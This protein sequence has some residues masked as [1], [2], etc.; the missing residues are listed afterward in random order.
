MATARSNAL[1][2][3]QKLEEIE[4]AIGDLLY[5]I[6]FRESGKFQSAEGVQSTKPRQSFLKRILP[7]CCFSKAK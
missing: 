7:Y 2:R 5:R 3:S 6:K 1:V 4:C